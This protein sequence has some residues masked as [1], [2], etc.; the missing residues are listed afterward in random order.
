MALL[1][2]SEP[3]VLTGFELGIQFSQRTLLHSPTL[4]DMYCLFGQIVDDEQIAVATFS[5]SL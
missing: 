5:S 3:F 2:L 4:R 1:F